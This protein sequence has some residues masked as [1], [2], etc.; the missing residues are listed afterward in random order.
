[1][2]T[3][4]LIAEMRAYAA[5]NFYTDSWDVLLKWSDVQVAVVISGAKTRRG[6]IAKAWKWVREIDARRSSDP[7]LFREYGH[8]PRRPV[9]LMQFL[10]QQGGVAP[11]PELTILWR[12]PVYRWSWPAG[13]PHWRPTGRSAPHGR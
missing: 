4:E 1:M 8:K 12:Q 6:A 7:V 13:A 10:A 5:D 11:H 2:T 9:S 3:D